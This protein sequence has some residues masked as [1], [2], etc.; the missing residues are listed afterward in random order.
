MIL[1]YWQRFRRAWISLV[2]L[3]AIL[4]V[5]ITLLGQGSFA[6]FNPTC[7]AR[8]SFDP[9]V[10]PAVQAKLNYLYDNGLLYCGAPSV[11]FRTLRG[12]IYWGS[13]GMSALLFF[14][15][16]SLKGV[17]I[18]TYLYNDTYLVGPAGESPPPS[19]GEVRAGRPALVNQAP[20]D[21]PTYFYRRDGAPLDGDAVVNIEVSGPAMPRTTAPV[22]GRSVWR[23]IDR[24]IATLRGTSS[25]ELDAGTVRSSVALSFLTERWRADVRRSPADG[26]ADEEGR[27]SLIHLRDA[28][29]EGTLPA[30]PFVFQ[31]ASGTFG[32]S[33]WV[34]NV[35]TAT[36]P[37]LVLAP[38]VAPRGAVGGTGDADV[39]VPISASVWAS[40]AMLVPIAIFAFD[41]LPFP[42]ETPVEARFWADGTRRDDGAPPDHVWAVTFP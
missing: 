6:W 22:G 28:Q 3:L 4:A 29:L 37:A 35:V 36:R 12:P 17:G 24:L 9:G 26:F 33:L 40:A 23:D 42:A 25:T 21:A 15:A 7:D 8:P 10:D 13:D 39:I 18:A 34:A 41:A 5:A 16:D 1:Q 20:G 32:T 27:P 38:T 30:A 2:A 11:P 14:Q 31:R 19:Y